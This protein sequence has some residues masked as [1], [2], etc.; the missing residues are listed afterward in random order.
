LWR[1][2][3]PR[4]P[5]LGYERL[6]SRATQGV[7]RFGRGAIKIEIERLWRDQQIER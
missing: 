4:G 5:A 1:H 2:A 6:K 7:D 3:V